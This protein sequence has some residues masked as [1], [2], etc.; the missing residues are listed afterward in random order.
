MP[1]EYKIQVRSIPGSFN[2]ELSIYRLGPNHSVFIVHINDQGE[3]VEEMV[4]VKGTYIKPT[5]VADSMLI[6]AFVQAFTAYAEDKGY[7]SNVG[8]V[9]AG[10]LLAQ[11]A[12]LEDL[13]TLL[14]LKK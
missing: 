4:E 12:H 13:R 1:N 9:A 7:K 14:K 5:M 8:S 3:C 10:Q 6:R 2:D 11:S